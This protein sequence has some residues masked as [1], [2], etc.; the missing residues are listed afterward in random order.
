MT[1]TSRQILLLQLLEGDTDTTLHYSFWTGTGA[2]GGTSSVYTAKGRIV[3]IWRS[4]VCMLRACSHGQRQ[5]WR[6]LHGGGQAEE[7]G[8]EEFEA[9]GDSVDTGIVRGQVQAWPAAV[10]A[11]DMRTPPR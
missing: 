3:S 2:L 5:L 10:H 7:V 11:N 9:V 1:L 4:D 6:H 8:A